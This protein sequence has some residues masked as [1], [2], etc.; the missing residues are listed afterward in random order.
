MIIAS[1]FEALRGSFSVGAH[2]GLPTSLA[3]DCARVLGVSDATISFFGAFDQIL[4]SSSSDDA[5]RVAEWE[6]T[7]LEGPCFDAAVA[8][9]SN[10]AETAPSAENPWPQLSAKAQGL[11]YRCIG[12]IPWQVEGTFYTT[13]NIYDRHGSITL[14]TLAD[15]AQIA[16]GLAS[17]VVGSFAQQPPSSDQLGEHDTF[18]QATGMVMTQMRIDAR[19][20]V[21]VLRAHAWSHDRLL[22]DVAAEVVD[23]T[24][25][26][27][28][29]RP[30]F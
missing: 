28:P 6:F 2:W 13:L 1:D 5:R 12:G 20:A 30:P 15:A 18:H 8:G 9:T 19:S 7:L 29:A 4:L 17:L 16:E 23:R 14:E 11:G 24:L 22:M 10:F 25:T 26:F 3:T 21:D 27:A